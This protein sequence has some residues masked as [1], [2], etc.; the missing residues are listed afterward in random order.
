MLEPL[1]FTPDTPFQKLSF[2]DSAHFFSV[3]YKTSVK[4][5]CLSLTFA[6]HKI[7]KL[8]PVLKEVTVRYS[9]QKKP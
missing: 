2:Q 4:G 5:Q 9:C 1:S 7:E 8:V 6:Q 3:S